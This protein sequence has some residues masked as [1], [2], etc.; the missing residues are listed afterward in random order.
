MKDINNTINNDEDIEQV[1]DELWGTISFTKSEYDQLI[2]DCE[3]VNILLGG[4]A[5]KLSIKMFFQ[6]YILSKLVKKSES[7]KE[8]FKSIQ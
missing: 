3:S 5:T 2:A 1:M 6:E 8:V 4:N 7:F